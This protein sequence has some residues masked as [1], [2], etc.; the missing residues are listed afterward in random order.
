MVHMCLQDSRVCRIALL[1]SKSVWHHYFNYVFSRAL[2]GIFSLKIV[3]TY[4]WRSWLKNW[5]SFIFCDIIVNFEEGESNNWQRSRW[6]IYSTA[7]YPF[8]FFQAHDFL[9]TWPRLLDW[10]SLHAG[11]LCFLMESFLWRCILQMLGLTM[12]NGIVS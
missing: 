3:V 4:S 9:F 1:S 5:P 6:K 7:L 12:Q 11:H 10:N 8:N 2:G